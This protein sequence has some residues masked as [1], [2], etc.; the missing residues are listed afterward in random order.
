[1]HSYAPHDVKELG[2]EL[3]RAIVRMR[4]RPKLIRSF[5][6]ATHLYD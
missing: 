6:A 5:V 3:R 2:R 4:V 1:M